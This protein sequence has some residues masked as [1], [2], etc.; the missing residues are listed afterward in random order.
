MAVAKNEWD[1][2]E[3]V[4][5][6]NSNV[7]VRTY[8]LKVKSTS[9]STIDGK[10][11][12]HFKLISNDKPPVEI[13]VSQFVKRDTEG[14]LKNMVFDS[15][16]G[17]DGTK[18]AASLMWELKEAI[19]K[20]LGDEAYEQR[21]T[22]HGGINKGFFQ[23]AV[24]DFEVK[25]VSPK[26]GEPFHM[27]MTEYQKQRDAEYNANKTPAPETNSEDDINPSDLPF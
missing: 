7:E 27:L 5:K 25:K 2:N 23:D 26:S 10:E 9:M 22:L 18:V 16:E 13:E 12:I 14:K 20:E 6:S 19:R 4:E 15:F 24:F 11:A 21:K 3:N 17:N 8:R 1:S